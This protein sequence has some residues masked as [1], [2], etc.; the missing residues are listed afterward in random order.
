[1]A[2]TFFISVVFEDDYGRQTRKTYETQP[3]A[4][5]DVGADRLA[6]QTD[7][8]AFL[9]DVEAI[10]EARILAYTVADR[11]VYTDVVTAGANVDEGLTLV[12][13]KAD[14]YKAV[15]AVPAPVNSIFN[16][17]GTADITDPIV[18]N[19]HANFTAT[20][21]LTCS[22]GEIATDLISGRLDK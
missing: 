22:D 17:D 3:Y 21:F 19:Y 6:V 15:L 7:V 20:G 10:T 12:T 13:R 4:G 11:T 8:V 1:M 14:N 2:T 18:T 16:P 9:N 5:V